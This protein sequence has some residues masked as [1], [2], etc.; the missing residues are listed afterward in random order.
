[1]TQVNIVSVIQAALE[2]TD[3]RVRADGI[4]ISFDPPADPVYV[5][6][7]EVRLQQVIV[8]LMTNAMDA[9]AGQ[10]EKRIEIGITHKE[11]AI[12]VSVR[13]SGP[14][15]D[16]PDKIFDPFYTTK[17]VGQS[18]GMGLGL[19]ISY[20]LVQSFGGAIIGRNHPEGGAAFYVELPA[21]PTQEVAA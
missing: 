21:A 18:E 7:G 4:R 17:E 5:Q 19:S 6:G 20:G 1:M 15:L 2:L 3:T 13:D 12:C 11:D 8:N 14:G 10:P 9:M 16:D